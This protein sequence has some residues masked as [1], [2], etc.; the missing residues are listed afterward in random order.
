MRTF[1][2]QIPGELIESAKLD[3]AGE[4]R[5]FFTI[6][7]PLSK[8]LIATISLTSMVGR[9]NEWTIPLIYVTRN[10]RLYTLQYILQRMLEQAE[11]IKN[12]ILKTPMASRLLNTAMIP[13]LSMRYAMTVI[14]A[15]PMLI[16]FP[17]FQK[18][19]T[20]GL[21]AGAVKG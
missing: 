10:D 16:V 1:F 21:T 6:I 8:P 20:R 14:A 17:F 15:G 13:T 11:F 12:T 3:G 19:F 4:F 2:Q 9:W 7:V 18:Y 5:I